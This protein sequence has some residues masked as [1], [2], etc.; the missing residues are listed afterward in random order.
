MNAFLRI[1]SSALLSFAVLSVRAQTGVPAGLP[2][3]LKEQVHAYATAPLGAAPESVWQFDLEGKPVYYIPA[4]CC[5]QYDRLFAADGSFLCAP[6]GGLTG[7]GDRRCP[8]ILPK[9]DEMKLIWQH[10]RRDTKG[11]AKASVHP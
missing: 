10:P 11:K 8:G 7:R 5:D 2:E 6:S 4:P 1:F 9:R 3:W